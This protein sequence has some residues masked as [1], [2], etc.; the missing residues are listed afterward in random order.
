MLQPRL[1]D[2]EA[3]NEVLAQ[4]IGGPDAE[5]RAALG[6]DAIADADDG[7]EIIMSE[8]AADA[9]AAFLLNYRVI[10]DSCRLGKL[11]AVIDIF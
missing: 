1:V 3:L 2:S 11:L 4:R 7:I 6:I 5:L 8:A 9:P 10:L